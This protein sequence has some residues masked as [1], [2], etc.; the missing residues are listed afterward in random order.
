MT[1]GT[2]N[3]KVYAKDLQ[4][5]TQ[6][7]LTPF[8]GENCK[9][10]IGKPKLFFIQAC[11]GDRVDAGTQIDS[12]NDSQ[13]ASEIYVIPKNADVLVMY[14]TSE[15]HVSFREVDQGSWF[16]QALCEEVAENP[17]EDLLSILTGVNSKVAFGRQASIPDNNVMDGAKQMPQIISTLTKKM[18]FKPVQ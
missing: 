10:L 14:S 18:F 6:D 16:I 11:R 12:F 4:F 9:N 13:S 1:H 8:I 7:L 17:E 2:R 3:D 15:D 5:C